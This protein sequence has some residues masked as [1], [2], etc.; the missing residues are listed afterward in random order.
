MSRVAVESVA[1]ALLELVRVPDVSVLISVEPTSEMSP[2]PG[3]EELNPVAPA[4]LELASVLYVPVLISVEP[5]SEILPPPDVEEPAVVDSEFEGP[6]SSA[7]AEE[8]DPSLVDDE[9]V[10]LLV[11]GDAVTVVFG[12]PGSGPVPGVPREVPVAEDVE[13][14]VPG[15]EGV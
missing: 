1:P 13:S 6:V 11:S 9:L 15:A 7:A 2:P 8:L 14:P 12:E 10:T 5:A 3:V 4:L